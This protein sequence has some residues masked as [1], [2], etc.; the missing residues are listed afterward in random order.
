MKKFIVESLFFFAAV[1]L[2]ADYQYYFTDSLT[3]LDAT[4][5]SPTGAP[6]VGPAGLAATDTNGGSWIS[7][8]PTPDG[9]SEAEVRI[10][11]R[12]AASGGK[13]TAFLGASPDARTAATGSGNYLAFE[14]Q[15]PEFDSAGHCTATFVVFEAAG[16][17][18]SLLAT[19]QHTC[20]NGMVMRLAVQAGIAFVW[21]DEATPIKLAISTP[22]LG[23][24]GIGLAG[25]PPGNTISQVQLGAIDRAAPPAIQTSRIG[26]SVFR[27]RVDAQ[28]PPITAASTSSGLAGYAIYRD[29]RYLL[30][31][32]ATTFSDETVSPGETH[33]YSIYS[34]NQHGV[35]SAAASF[36]ASMPVAKPPG[37]AQP[38]SPPGNGSRPKD[39]KQNPRLVTVNTPP[40]DSGNG[41]DPRRT[42]I[43]A[44][45]TY[46]GGAGEQIDTT[47]GNLNFSL[48]LIKAM[49][50]GNWSIQFVLSYNSQMWRENPAG[51]WAMGQDVGYGLGWKLQVGSITPIWNGS[52][53]DHYLFTD[54][55]G[56]EYNLNV[57]N[58]NVWT[59][60]E[61]TFVTYDANQ[62]KLFSTDG[63][64]WVMGSTSASGEQ[65][66]GTLYPTLIEDT[67]GNQITISYAPGI[68]GNGA[69]NTSAR[70]TQIM[71]ARVSS[72]QA[73]YYSF[74][75]N[76][77]QPINHL[78]SI[79]CGNLGTY[80]NYGFNYLESQPYSSP[81][82]GASYG[83]TALLQSIVVTGPSSSNPLN[84]GHSFQ[85]DSSGEM[86]QM[87]TPLGGSLQ[88]AYRTFTYAGNISLRE[89]QYRNM[90]SL[91]GA[92]WWSWVFT[93]P[94]SYDANQTYH[95]WTDI[96]DG[97]VGTYRDYWQ[98]V[99]GNGLNLVTPLLF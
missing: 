4:K 7:K 35:L 92:S 12:L 38:P 62:Q 3:S 19:F 20:R 49:A 47:S 40:A 74:S 8:I 9:S 51:I 78:T 69:A 76:N 34:V 43:R 85:Y 23:Q 54:A 36:T 37:G 53:V 56:A 73:Q 84:I 61:G 57:N 27:K 67:N 10:T 6:T 97:S 16:G 87:T 30:T 52:G 1:P 46:W 13:Y 39:R 79:S 2:W 44:Y 58:G 65:D 22:A 94:D 29:G 26:V 91:P 80:E 99:Y 33:T 98:S 59:S 50:R 31:T 21:P 48:P 42:G 24:P 66:S 14:M 68:G 15:D 18:T 28:W 95:E 5:W 45:G 32:S 90:Q 75:Y 88:W 77:D 11:L 89:V 64:F 41:L 71:D 25:T 93:R 70:I 60:L 83:T 81:I 96:H 17:A 82:S 72:S 63:S 55:T 86:T